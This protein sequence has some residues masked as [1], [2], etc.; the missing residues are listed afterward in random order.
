MARN[1]LRHTPFDLISIGSYIRSLYWRKYLKGLN[2]GKFK[3][4]LDAGYGAGDYAKKLETEHPHLI[5]N[6]Y[7]IKKYESWNDKVN[8]VFIK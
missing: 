7:D 6:A 5:I 2:P 1:L 4:V 3:T 8:N